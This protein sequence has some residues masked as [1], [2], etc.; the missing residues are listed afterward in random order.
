MNFLWKTIAIC[1]KEDCNPT[2]LSEERRKNLSG[3]NGFER[4]LNRC[5]TIDDQIHVSI[6]SIKSMADYRIDD[7]VS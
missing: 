2:S 1:S 7:G 4:L 6:S 5:F 3:F